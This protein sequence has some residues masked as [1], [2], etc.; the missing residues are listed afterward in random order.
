M[1]LSGPRTEFLFEQE[2]EE[3]EEKPIHHRHYFAFKRNG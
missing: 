3:E 1:E 2:E